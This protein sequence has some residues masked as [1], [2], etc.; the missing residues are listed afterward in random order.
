MRLTVA[1]QLGRGLWC[2]SDRHMPPLPAAETTLA[3]LPEILPCLSPLPKAVT[4]CQSGTMHQP[5]R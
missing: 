5:Y 3:I 1:L 4:V 2:P